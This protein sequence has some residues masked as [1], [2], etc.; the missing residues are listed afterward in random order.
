[1]TTYI[2]SFAEGAQIVM[3]TL[4]EYQFDPEQNERDRHAIA[5]WLWATRRYPQFWRTDDPAGELAQ[6]L[7][8][9][10][11]SEQEASV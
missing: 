2:M 6:R 10:K 8:E 9:L 11:A 4:P 1:M 3:D 5:W 7:R